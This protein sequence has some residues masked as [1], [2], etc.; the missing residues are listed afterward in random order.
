MTTTPGQAARVTTTRHNRD[1][2][3][4]IDSPE[5]DTIAAP[6]HTH[7][8]GFRSFEH[9]DLNAIGT[10]DQD[11]ADTEHE[12]QRHE[13]GESRTETSG[14]MRA[15]HN[16]HHGEAGASAIRERSHNDDAV[17]SVGQHASETTPGVSGSWHGA[18]A[19]DV[20]PLLDFSG[21]PLE[22][23]KLHVP[24]G[25]VWQRG[26]FD[27]PGFENIIDLRHDLFA[28]APARST[29]KSDALAQPHGPQMH[30]G[31]FGFGGG[32]AVDFV[33]NLASDLELGGANSRRE[34]RDSEACAAGIEHDSSLQ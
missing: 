26:D 27:L 34:I 9:A 6:A 15:H 14:G 29:A 7:L 33:H 25:A 13:T 12:W 1:F 8:S 16:N 10:P 19:L 28:D 32:G 31:E 17:D 30:G 5:T 11:T 18:N 3:T 21:I 22:G 2:N 23:A 24:S 20:G 4:A